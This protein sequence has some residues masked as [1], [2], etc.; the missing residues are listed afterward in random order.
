MKLYSESEIKNKLKSAFWNTSA[1]ADD[2]Y[3]V[4]HNKRNQIYSIN[5]S[6]IFTRLLNT[7]DWYDILR[8]IPYNELPLALSN[9]A[10]EKLWPESLQKR[11]LHARRILFEQSLPSAK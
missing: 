4:L 5:K 3:K 10:L 7:Y 2:L 1:T 9:E 11:Y 6:A 8:I